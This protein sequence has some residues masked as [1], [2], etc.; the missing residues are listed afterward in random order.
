MAYYLNLFDLN[1][2]LAQLLIGG[3]ERQ[4]SLAVEHNT[5]HTVLLNHTGGEGVEGRRLGDELCTH[6]VLLSFSIH[7]QKRNNQTIATHSIKSGAHCPLQ[8]L[9]E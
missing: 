7:A 5:P 9:H 2:S 6:A 3:K 1:I 4:V 8:K